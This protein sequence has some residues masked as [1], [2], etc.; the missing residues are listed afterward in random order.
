[1]NTSRRQ[2]VA[3]AGL[4]LA[5]PAL[6]QAPRK[7]VIGVMG[8]PEGQAV[9]SYAEFRKR[10][11]E[12]GY[13]E[14]RNLQIE[15]RFGSSPDSI[16]AEFARRK[17][18]L[19]VAG[20][21]IN[22][23]AAMRATSAIPILTQSGDPVEA[24]LTRSLARPTSNVTGAPTSSTSII[25]KQVEF[26]KLVAP[27]FS[28]VGVL[29]NPDNRFHTAQVKEAET[30][31]RSLGGQAVP[32]AAR[33]GGQI[34][35]ALEEMLKAKIDA[36]LKLADGAVFFPGQQTV[37][38][39]AARHRL[40]AIYPRRENVEAGGLISYGTDRRSGYRRLAD[41]AGK[42]F[43][44]AKVADLPFEQADKF[45][46]VINR[47][48]AKALGIRLPQSILGRADEVIG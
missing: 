33:G 27:R 18:D 35:A 11:R 29:W 31:I 38:R 40:P 21:T 41:Y 19:I 16:A 34:E 23:L 37:I 12:L 5:A 32:A 43:K 42:L 2:F 36:L 3:A 14:G 15:W 47:V 10:L 9:A 17:V 8:N 26:L 4:L 44:G 25:G 39:F 48:T 6:A 7:F 13:E 30:A 22:A 45:E 46:L 20:S 24:G 28:R 1:M